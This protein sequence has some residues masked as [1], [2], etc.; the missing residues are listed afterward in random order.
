MFGKK[1]WICQFCRNFNY[2]TR[3][4]CNRCHN[5]KQAKKLNKIKNIFSN[6]INEKYI[7]NGWHCN[8]CGNF[9][10]S[11]RVICNRCKLQTKINMS[12]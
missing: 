3:K 1:G 9:N 6:Y 4:K 12:C 2:A 5:K 7:E 11:F 10:Y 8:Y